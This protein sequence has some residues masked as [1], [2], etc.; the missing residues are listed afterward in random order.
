MVLK[1][2]AYRCFTGK[3]VNNISDISDYKVG[4]KRQNLPASVA[5]MCWLTTD[6]YLLLIG[7][8][9][10]YHGSKRTRDQMLHVSE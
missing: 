10:I 4:K 6:L 5:V 2:K 8:E 3:L 9:S 7:E 1:Q